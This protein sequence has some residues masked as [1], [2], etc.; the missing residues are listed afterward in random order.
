M[1]K[2]KPSKPQA[3]ETQEMPVTIETV[4]AEPLKTTETVEIKPA[5][6]VPVA[7]VDPDHEVQWIINDDTGEMRQTIARAGY[8]PAPMPFGFRL[9][10]ANEVSGE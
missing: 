5:D 4:K 6:A 1:A 8:A 3:D 7:P 10:K 9:A 2:R